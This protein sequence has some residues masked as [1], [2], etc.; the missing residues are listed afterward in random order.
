MRSRPVRRCP[1][2]GLGDMELAVLTGFRGSALVGLLEIYARNWT[3]HH[4]EGTPILLSSDTSWVGEVGNVQVVQPETGTWKQHSG[5]CLLVV[6]KEARAKLTPVEI[7]NCGDWLL[8]GEGTE[9]VVTW[10][11]AL[12]PHLPVTKMGFCKLEIKELSCRY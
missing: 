3:R 11:P 6:G 5:R 10:W 8:L 4:P 7:G 2:G 1:A 9:E 12:A